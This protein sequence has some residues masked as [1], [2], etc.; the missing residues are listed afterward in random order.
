MGLLDRLLKPASVAQGAAMAFTK[1]TC[2]HYTRGDALGKALA[3]G[4][5][6]TAH[7]LVLGVRNPGE[8]AAKAL[9]AETKA[10]LAAPAEAA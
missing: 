4:F 7:K 8:A 2:V 10:E 1:V 9:A 6:K 5:A 3:H